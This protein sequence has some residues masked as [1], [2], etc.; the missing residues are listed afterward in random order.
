MPSQ[1][2]WRGLVALP[3]IEAVGRALVNL[4]RRHG[5][6]LST[7]SMEIDEAGTMLGT[8]SYMSPEQFMG[9]TVDARTDL[10][11]AGVMLYQLLTGEKPFEGGL[12]AIMHKV[13]NTEPP[14]S[15]LSVTVLPAFDAGVRKA[16]AGKPETGEI[17]REAADFADGEATVVAPRRPVSAPPPPLEEAPASMPAAAPMG[18]K[19]SPNFALLAGLAGVGAPQAALNAALN[20]LPNPSQLTNRN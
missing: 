12:T 19:R 4:Y 14:P 5:Y 7:V 6:I 2:A 15:V 17:S 3:E 8:P 1:Q 10:Y 18:A 13:L 9:Q 16:F 20:S 11:S